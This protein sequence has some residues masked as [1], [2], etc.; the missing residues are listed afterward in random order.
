LVITF[1][2]RVFLQNDF[3]P[4]AVEPTTGPKV[5]FTLIMVMNPTI[6]PGYHFSWQEPLQ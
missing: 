4:K 2:W 6:Y 1:L 3:G 5:I